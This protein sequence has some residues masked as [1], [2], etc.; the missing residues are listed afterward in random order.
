MLVILTRLYSAE[1]AFRTDK[2]GEKLPWYQLAPGKFPPEGS[3]HYIGGELIALDHVN[4]TGVLRQDRTPATVRRDWDR[5]LPFRLLPFGALTFRGAP[6]EL[7]DIPLGT[8]LHGQFYFGFEPALKEA[9]LL[10]ETLT[11]VVAEDSLRSY[12]QGS[13]R[14]RAEI[15]E[16]Q[17]VSPGSGNSGVRIKFKPT[18]LLEGFR[19]KRIVRLF[20]PKWKVDALPKEERIYQTLYP[21]GGRWPESSRDVYA[22]RYRTASLINSE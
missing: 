16:I 18:A 11:V 15:L 22:A 1:P 12:D 6:A 13:D 20:A 8:H 10:K 14:M 9:F 7:R 5:P 3:A 2:G 17:R 19:P 4:R 21:S